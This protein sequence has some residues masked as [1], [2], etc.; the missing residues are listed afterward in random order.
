MKEEWLTSF[1]QALVKFMVP[2]LSNYSTMKISFWSQSTSLP[3][4]FK[5]FKIWVLLL[6]KI[7]NVVK[8][9]WD[10]N[11]VISWLVV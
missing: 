3:K 8:E 9:V 4:P 7:F 1:K 5:F 10:I 2:G 6:G 11:E